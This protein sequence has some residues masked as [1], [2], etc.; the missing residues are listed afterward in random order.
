MTAMAQCVACAPRCLVCST[1]LVC[2]AC[3]RPRWSLQGTACECIYGLFDL[4]GTCTLCT[5]GCMTCRTS[6]DSCYS[7][8]LEFTYNSAA[9]TCTCSPPT[10]LSRVGQRFCS[11]CLPRCA[12]CSSQFTCL[13]CI[14]GF[15]LNATASTCFCAEY[16]VFEAFPTQTCRPCTPYCLICD[17]RLNCKTCGPNYLLNPEA[18]SCICAPFFYNVTG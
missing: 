3:N 5:S 17:S 18:P 12:T 6:A 8:L 9:H 7:C 1:L 16:F 11:A 14:P 4:D 2:T 13:S 15:T 10:F